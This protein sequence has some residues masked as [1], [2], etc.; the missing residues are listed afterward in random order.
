MGWKRTV[1]AKLRL[2]AD[3][4]R[5]LS[6]EER[7][8]LFSWFCHHCGRFVPGEFCPRCAPASPHSKETP[9]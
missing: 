4:L 5:Q 8:Y 1:P 7:L 2:I 9:R 3:G 6:D